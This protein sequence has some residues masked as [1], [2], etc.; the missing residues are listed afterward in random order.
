MMSVDGGLT[1]V[2]LSPL[3]SIYAK[4]RM[5]FTAASVTFWEVLGYACSL[6]FC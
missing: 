3:A 1:L 4:V 6:N 5:A 2:T